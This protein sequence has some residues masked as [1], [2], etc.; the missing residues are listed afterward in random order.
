[1]QQMCVDDV[2]T[3]NYSQVN[4]SKDLD[5]I[6]NDSVNDVVSY[7]CEPFDCNSNGRCVNGSCVC[8]SGMSLSLSSSSPSSLMSLMS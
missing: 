2:L 6:I 8:N 7:R 1:M 4:D 3:G 5:T